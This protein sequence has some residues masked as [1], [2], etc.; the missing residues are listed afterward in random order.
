MAE[1]N[2]NRPGW[3]RD[4]PEAP[5]GARAMQVGSRAGAAELGV[6]LYELDPG[7][8]V[9]PYHSHHANEELL[10][11]LSGEPALRTPEGTRRLE[12]GDVVGF[13]R[14]PEG[15]HRISNPGE[16]PARVVVHSTM[17][18]PDVAEYPDTGAV[19]A[20]TGPAEGR[21]FPA[22]AD[23]PPLECVTRAMEA[24]AERER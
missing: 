13:P 15:A 5:F 10:V 23:V 22:G 1:L 9:S 14:G 11:V 3:D 20:M 17:H 7:G 18:L 12:P 4:L 8:A 24:A 19:L 6:T 16:Q 21:T 2:I